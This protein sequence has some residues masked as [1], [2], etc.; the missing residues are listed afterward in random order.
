MDSG[1]NL[2]INIRPGVAI[3]SVLP[4]LNYQPWFALAEFVDNSIQSFQD[5]QE[6]I[7]QIDGAG[8]QL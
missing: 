5:C 3:L 1:L 7:A 2:R 8:A 6:A 4:H